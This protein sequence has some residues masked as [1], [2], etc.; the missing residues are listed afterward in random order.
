MKTAHDG[1]P[2]LRS[3][4]Q[5]RRTSSTG[6]SSSG[7]P[8]PPRW[9]APSRAAQ[10]TNQTQAG[11]RLLALASA[12]VVRPATPTTAAGLITSRGVAASRV[13]R[14]PSPTSTR[15][16][17]RSVI[18]SCGRATRAT[19]TPRRCTRPASTGCDRSRLRDAHRSTTCSNASTFVRSTG[20]KVAARSGGH[21][22]AGYS[23][24]SGLVIDVAPMKQRRN[25]RREQ[26]AR[27]GAGATLIDV[28][29]G[30][31]TRQPGDR[32]RIVSVGRHRR[33]D[34]RR[35][36]RRGRAQVRLDLRRASPRS[37]SSLL[38]EKLLHCSENASPTST[39]HIAAVAAATSASSPRLE[40]RTHET[41]NLTRLRRPVGLVQRTQRRN[42]LAAM[43][44]DHPD[45]L[46]AS[47][48]HR[49]RRVVV[50]ITPHVYVE[51]RL[52]RL[53]PPACRRCSTRCSRPRKRR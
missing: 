1:F 34:T 11:R 43:V 30:L 48:A 42:R 27:I 9:W 3:L 29:S 50:S 32:R 17:R 5:Q 4:P 10:A 28:Y 45:E 19:S 37:T 41:P 53:A 46:W 25:D 15:W 26:T 39:G 16:R 20:T 31:A 51:R 2:R 13:E 44:A 35:R 22:Y 24:T 33:I 21:S 52:R 18:G 47:L 14:R 23:T 49:R 12:S 7:S 40:F 38:T 8:A 36:G 6:A